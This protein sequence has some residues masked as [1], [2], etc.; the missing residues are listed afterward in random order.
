MNFYYTKYIFKIKMITR[1]YFGEF[2]GNKFRGN[3]GINLKRICCASIENI[4]DECL[5]N[6]NCAYNIIF[7]TPQ[8]GEIKLGKYETPPKPFIFK[9]S[10]LKTICNEEEVIEIPFILFGY[11]DKYLPYAAMAVN[12]MGR[13]GINLNGGN[14]YIDTIEK[15]NG[16]EKIQIYK[17][18]DNDIKLSEGCTYVDIYNESDNPNINRAYIQL[19]SPLRIKKNKKITNKFEFEDIVKRFFERIVSISYN[20][21]EQKEIVDYRKWIEASKTINIS[22]KKLEW[23]DMERYSYRKKAESNLGGYYGSMV[24]EGDNL[25]KFSSLL[26]LMEEINI[27]TNT[28]FGCGEIKIKKAFNL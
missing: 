27:G 20:Y 19:L 28:T 4:C 24:L 21:C 17:N 2:A 26:D 23:S 1:S 11:A 15:I 3:F 12:E 10:S 22:E 7:N 18:K 5:L 6:K 8:F 25:S 14:F 13:R 9:L 16:N